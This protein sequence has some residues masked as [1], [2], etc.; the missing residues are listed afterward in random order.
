MPMPEK[1]PVRRRA[2]HEP[3]LRWAHVSVRH[4]KPT[5]AHFAGITRQVLFGA[6]A[7]L[8]SEL[9]YFEI[10]PGGYSSLERHQHVHAVVVLQGAGRVVV[11][12]EVLAVRPFDLVTVPSETWHQFLA[13][14]DAPLG[15]LCVVPC[16]RDRPVPPT[17]AE[18]K[19][20]QAHPVIGGVVR[21]QAS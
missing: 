2:P 18:W 5:G 4:Y 11:G 21:G 3:G 6:D 10:A 13:E 19:S 7:G 15:F 14:A 8:P 17:E 20:L 12:E 16:D 9:R 1:S